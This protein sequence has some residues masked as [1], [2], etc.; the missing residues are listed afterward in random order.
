MLSEPPP[1]PT[2][3]CYT[4]KENKF[5]HG[6]RFMMSFHIKGKFPRHSYTIIAPKR[7]KAPTI[8][9]VSA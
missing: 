1:Q 5:V 4:D 9:T 2:K 3:D 7:K 6:I 8:T